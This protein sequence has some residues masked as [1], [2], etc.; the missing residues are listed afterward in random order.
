M[1]LGDCKLK[2]DITP[3]LLEWLKSTKLTIPNADKDIDQ[4]EHLFIAD[5]NAK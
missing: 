1:S 5:A 2:W 3:Y 4:K